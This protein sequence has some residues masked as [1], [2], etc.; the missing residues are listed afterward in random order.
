ME[1]LRVEGFESAGDVREVFVGL[2]GDDVVLCEE[3]SG[4][5]AQVAFGEKNHVLSVRLTPEAVSEVVAEIGFA[6]PEGSLWDY[7]A[8]ARYDLTDLA[9]LCAGRGIPCTVGAS[10]ETRGPKA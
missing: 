5:S 9:C 7:L 3:V 4:P 2:D 8:D 1:R 6:G 10:G